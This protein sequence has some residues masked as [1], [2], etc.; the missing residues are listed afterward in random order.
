MIESTSV[1]S[2]DMNRIEVGFKII[3]KDRERNQ[4]QQR[5]IQEACKSSWKIVV[6]AG[7]GVQRRIRRVEVAEA[8]KDPG[9]WGE[10]TGCAS[11]VETG[12][13]ARRKWAV[14]L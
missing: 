8:L 13:T 1:F 6:V 4:W 2:I 9:C 10:T 7:R 3:E 5:E 12:S 14:R 11:Q